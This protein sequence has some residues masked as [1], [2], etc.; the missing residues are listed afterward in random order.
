VVTVEQTWSA[1]AVDGVAEEGHTDGNTHG[2]AEVDT[3]QSGL[4]L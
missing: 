3:G 4:M 2:T 1:T